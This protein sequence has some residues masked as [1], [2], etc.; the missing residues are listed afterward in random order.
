MGK[1]LLKHLFIPPRN[2][3]GAERPEPFESGP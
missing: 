2:A 3:L 1:Y